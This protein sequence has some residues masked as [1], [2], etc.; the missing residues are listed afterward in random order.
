MNVVVVLST[1]AWRA[2]VV[3]KVLSKYA[4]EFL[5]RYGRPLT[6]AVVGVVESDCG[7]TISVAMRSVVP[8][9]STKVVVMVNVVLDVFAVIGP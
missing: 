2:V 8:L 7:R 9:L 5:T 1:M 4:P 3:D 6:P